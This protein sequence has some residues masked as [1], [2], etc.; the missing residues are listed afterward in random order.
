ML[1]LVFSV[2]ALDHEVG[3]VCVESLGFLDE[4]LDCAV[5]LNQLPLFLRKSNAILL[6]IDT[7]SIWVEFLWHLTLAEGS[8]VI[9][10]RV[11]PS[12][13]RRVVSAGLMLLNH[14]PFLCQLRFLSC[15]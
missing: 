15:E 4:M 13:E 9:W 3:E 12:R 14:R 10:I 7:T 2:L 1:V 11:L 5:F 6:V 8:E